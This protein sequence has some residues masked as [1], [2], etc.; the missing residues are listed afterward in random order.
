MTLYLQKIFIRLITLRK[1]RKFMNN[2]G[3]KGKAFKW[4]ASKQLAKIYIQEENKDKALELISK[5]YN[6][7]ASKDIYETFDYAE[8]LKN[9]EKFEES[10]LHYTK[11]IM[12]LRKNHPLYPSLTDG[13]G[14]AYERTGEWDKAEK[15]LLASLE[16]D[17]E[18]AY[19]INYLAYS[20]IE[21]GVKIR[22]IIKH[23]KKS[24]QIKIKRSLYHR[25]FGLG[26]IQT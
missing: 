1:L 20:W 13:R 18:Q 22:K 5:A 25:L 2:L 12:K 3:K 11:V 14:V 19:V 10:I 7:L 4:Y 21:Q 16:A 8:F 6:N 26:L 17:P 24:K 9:N 23:A 15:D